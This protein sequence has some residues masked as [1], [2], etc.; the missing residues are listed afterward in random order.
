MPTDP[1]KGEPTRADPGIPGRSQE[2]ERNPEGAAEPSRVTQS[3]RD[4]EKEVEP[5]RSK[6]TDDSVTE[7]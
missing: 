3:Q 4:L 2:H 5:D 7:S 1:R 6:P